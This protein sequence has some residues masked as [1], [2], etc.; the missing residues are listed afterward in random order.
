MK[1]IRQRIKEVTPHSRCHA[2]IREVVAQ[3]NPILRG[4]GEYFRTGNAATKFQQVDDYV[5]QRLL[6][7]KVKQK[8]RHLKP[9]EVKRWT[10][11]YFHQGF[12]LVRLGGTIQYPEAA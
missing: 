4:W 2:D 7:L 12:D 3:I 11:D 1:R 10:R 6:S 9:G 5:R 8:G